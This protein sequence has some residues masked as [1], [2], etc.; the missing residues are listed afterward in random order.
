VSQIAP[1][2]D[3]YR[4][5]AEL[6]A[7][8]AMAVW[9]CPCDKWSMCPSCGGSGEFTESIRLCMVEVAGE[10]VLAVAPGEIGGCGCDE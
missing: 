8:Q 5:G 10:L 1:D 3:L 2:L 7:L 4:E 9:S 6:V